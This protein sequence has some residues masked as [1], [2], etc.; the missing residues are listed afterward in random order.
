MAPSRPPTLPIIDLSTYTT[1]TPPQQQLIAHDLAH[2]CSSLGFVY[3]AGHGL[4][5]EQIEAAFAWSKKFFDLPV[6]DK[7]KAPHPDGPSVHRGYSHPGLE[8]VSQEIGPDDELGSRARALRQVADYKVRKAVP[9]AILLLLLLFL[10]PEP[11]PQPKLT[12][13]PA[14]QQESYELGAAQ[15]TEQPNVWPPAPLLPG[16]RPFMTDF[17]WAFHHTARLVLSVLARGIGL[18]DGETEALLRLHSGLNNQLRLLHY[19][20]V[21]AADVRAGKVARMPA[22]SDWRCVGVFVCVWPWEGEV[23][24]GEWGGGCFVGAAGRGR[25]G[26]KGMEATRGRRYRGRFP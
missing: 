2:A 18:S 12:P 8:K 26:G 21:R 6:Q 4:A 22:H 23:R 7:M 19:P 17:Y 24:D 10:T 15:N 25:S 3:I 16:F 11:Q 20:P 14:T 5:P 9:F 13:S 1:S